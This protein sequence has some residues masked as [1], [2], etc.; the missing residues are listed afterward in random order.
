MRR[1]SSDIPSVEPTSATA[2]D[3]WQW[4]HMSSTY[5]RSDGWVPAYRFAGPAVL[6]WDD[7]FTAADGEG[8]L[9]TVLASA[10]EQLEAGQYTVFRIFTLDDERYTERVGV[11]PIAADPLKLEPGDEVFWAIPARD[12]VRAAIAGR[13]TTAQMS[14]MIG[15][16]Q[17]MSYLPEQLMKLEAWLTAK[18]ARR[19]RNG[20]RR[21]LLVTFGNRQ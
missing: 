2:G 9:F 18:I 13:A 4:R 5:P 3:T 19:Q 15:G 20:R 14:S 8:W 1:M 12:A 17:V 6:E 11:I 7:D 16:R 10:T 21:Q